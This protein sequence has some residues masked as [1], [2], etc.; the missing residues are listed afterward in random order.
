VYMCNIS[1]PCTCAY[2]SQLARTNV[3]GIKYA[4]IHRVSKKTSTHIIGYKL[5]NSC[6]ILIIFDTNANVE[7]LR[8]RIVDEWERL[9]QRIIDGAVKEWRKRLRACAAAEGGQFEHEL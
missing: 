4:Y 3:H 1:M 7:E 9:D 2:R 5:R 6:P 8:Q